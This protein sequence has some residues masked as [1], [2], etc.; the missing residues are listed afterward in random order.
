MLNL[1]LFSNIRFFTLF[2][3]IVFFSNHQN[4]YSLDTSPN[5]NIQYA[6]GSVEFSELAYMAQKLRLFPEILDECDREELKH[7]MDILQSGC[8][9]LIEKIETAVERLETAS[10]YDPSDDE[11]Y[12]INWAKLFYE[13]QDD[14]RNTDG[15]IAYTEPY[16]TPNGIMYVGFAGT[17][18]LKGDTGTTDAKF[19]KIIP[20]NIYC[21]DTKENCKKSKKYDK[22]PKVHLGFYQSIRSVLPYIISTIEDNLPNKIFIAGHSLGGALAILAAYGIHWKIPNQENIL[23]YGIAAPRVGDKLFKNKMEQMQRNRNSATIHLRHSKDIVP[24]LP[25]VMMGYRHVG[26]GVNIGLLSRYD[27]I[28]YAKSWFTG[29][30]ASAYCVQMKSDSKLRELKNTFFSSFISFFNSA[31]DHL[32]TPYRRSLSELIEDNMDEE[33]AGI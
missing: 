3:Y 21:N 22:H 12:E 6:L 18:F 2:S 11:N 16:G 27:P 15:F 19:K 23:T 31:Q 26:K 5:L 28:N 17:E 10:G 9:P 1:R 24:T 25:P 4:T 13:L 8:D 32:L 7:D 29:K 33:C 14:G 30:S 20:W